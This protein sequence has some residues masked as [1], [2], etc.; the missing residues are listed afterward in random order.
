MPTAEILSQGDEV[1]T[2]QIA[3]TNAAWLA[4]RLTELG[5]EVVR[6][7]TVGDSLEAIRDALREIAPRCDLCLGTGGL[8]P[9]DDDWTARAVAEAFD[10]PL[11][12]DE[13]AMAQIEAIYAKFKRN[14]PEVNR[15]QAWLPSGA[16][17]IDNSWGTAPGFAVDTAGAGGRALF[18]FMPGVPREMKPMF[19]QM[20]LPVLRERFDLRP[21]RLVTLRTVGVAE[22]ELQQRLG[23]W[24]HPGV[25]VGYRTILPE[26]W[27]KL[28]LSAG[29]TDADAAAIAD[30]L[31]RRIGTGV[32]AV[33]G[34]GA[35]GGPLAEV[36]GRLLVSRQQTLAVAE[37]CTGGQIAA[38][39]T[40]IPG[41]SAWFLEGAITYSNAAKTR[42]LGVPA[43]TIER[44]GAVSAEVAMQMATGVRERSGA[45][46]GLAVT[47]VA[48]PGGGS[49]EKPVG[50]VH[51]ALATSTDVHHRLLRLGGDR[52]RIQ[53]LSASGAL[54]LV[55]RHL[56][57]V[58]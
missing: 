51:V 16:R 21:G 11:V 34:L 29:V 47:G 9:T 58:L 3:D 49:P 33:E 40:A 24:S 13:V 17:R 36:I 4:E 43:D 26:N 10:R 28:R 20:I 22:S 2:G 8:G 14:M 44:H 45:S 30:E 42:V 52:S 56:E 6:H 53:S 18:A 48:G 38:Q 12:F 37:S 35:P 27:V 5:F 7:T 39:C 55:R 46:Y 31:K 54:D 1:V 25:V 32:F 23:G 15:R 50:T 57:G 19:D 41:A